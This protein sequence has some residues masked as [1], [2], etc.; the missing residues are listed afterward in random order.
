MCD[1][2]I[3]VKTVLNLRQIT[4]LLLEEL[5]LRERLWTK[6]A[7]LKANRN[8]GNIVVMC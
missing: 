3:I 8:Q 2:N 1:S 4:V 5:N 7:T 6:T